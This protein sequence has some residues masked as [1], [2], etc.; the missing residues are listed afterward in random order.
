[1]MTIITKITLNVGAEPEWDEAMRERLEAAKSRS[2]WIG[3][4]VLV[5]LDALNQRLI[6]GTWETRADWEAWHEDESFK[7]VRERFDELEREKSES[8]WY[9]VIVDVRQ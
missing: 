8:S 6:I 9:E 3:G 5:P 2:G 1:M 4:K 7:Q